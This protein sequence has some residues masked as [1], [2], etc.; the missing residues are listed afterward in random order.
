MALMLVVLMVVTTITVTVV[1]TAI[2][3]QESSRTAAGRSEARLLG[4]YTLEEFAARI[5]DDPLL[6]ARA[7]TAMMNANSEELRE[8]HPALR[9]A[10]AENWIP[11]PMPQSRRPEG[12]TDCATFQIDCYHLTVPLDSAV[13]NP[14]NP[15]AFTVVTTVRLRCGGEERRCVYASFQQRLRSAQFFDFLLSHELTTLAP[16]ALFAS[17]S[18]QV[19]A[20]TDAVA[21]AAYKAACSEKAS[22]REQVS[23]LPSLTRTLGVTAPTDGVYTATG[24]ATVRDC[25]DIAYQSAGAALGK[26]TL[27]GPIYTADDYITVCDSPTLGDVFVSG[28]GA[29]GQVYRA[30]PNCGSAAPTRQTSGASWVTN[31]PYLVQPTSEAVIDEA[32]NEVRNRSETPLEFDKSDPNSP[33][34]LRFTPNGFTLT[35]VVN[36][37]AAG[38]PYDGEIIVIRTP[39]SNWGSV[40]VLVSGTVAGVVSIVVDGSVAIDDDLVY[41]QAV[42][43]GCV[44]PGGSQHNDGCLARN[45]DDVLS[46]TAT[47]RIEVWQECQNPGDQSCTTGASADR[48]IHGVF[49]SP[50]GYVGVPDWQDNVDSAGS[51]RGTLHF[52]GAVASRFQGV[53]GSYGPAAGGTRALLSGFNKSFVHDARLTKYTRGQGSLTGLPP[54]I[55][56][57]RVPV[58]VRLDVSEVGVTAP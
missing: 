52:Y 23:F 37:P 3:D 43:D 40:D 5:T 35:G 15:V 51:A 4:L 38:S 50:Q 55:V 13:P 44:T 46:L 48:F 16:E 11:L 27:Q 31:Q 58:W 24:S 17:G 10:S 20:S 33:V 12:V 25:V 53:Y 2:R 42:V 9:L 22:Q 6:P 21:Y 1:S 57:A 36:P 56:S 18:W 19:P 32:L 47:E 8:A 49:T 41:E 39:S 54:Y 34:E 29:S 14:Q 45:E 26:D 30:A 28:P 7:F